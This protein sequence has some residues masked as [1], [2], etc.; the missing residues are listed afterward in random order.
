MFF[1]KYINFDT[2]NALKNQTKVTKILQFNHYI[3]YKL[4]YPY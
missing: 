2:L 4:S 3:T 1:Y